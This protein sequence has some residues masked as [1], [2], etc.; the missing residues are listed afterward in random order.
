MASS[1]LPGR[2]SVNHHTSAVNL[3]LVGMTELAR[4]FVVGSGERKSAGGFMIEEA[5][6]PVHGIVAQ[7]AIDW[8]RSLLELAGVNV[9]VAADATFGCRLERNGSVAGR[10]GNG[11][12]GPV[13]IDAGQHLVAAHQRKR[14]VPMIK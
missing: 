14:R 12:N 10:D 5:G 11:G 6:G 13:A 4:N 1:A 8:L 9:F 3:L 7:A 2:A